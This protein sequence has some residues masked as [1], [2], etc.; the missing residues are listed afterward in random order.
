[1]VQNNI[2]ANYW[3]RTTRKHSVICTGVVVLAS[4]AART[5]NIIMLLPLNWCALHYYGNLA[6]WPTEW[7][8]LGF[9]NANYIS[10]NKLTHTERQSRLH[11]YNKHSYPFVTPSIDYT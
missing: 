11:T 3:Y 6:R 5:I 1:M 8:H 4:P 7:F 10:N 2:N 9:H